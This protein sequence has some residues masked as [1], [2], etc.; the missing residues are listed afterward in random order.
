MIE[1]VIEKEMRGVVIM[2]TE[3]MRRIVLAAL[4][5]LVMCGAAS[6]DELHVPSQYVTIQAAID[7]AVN[8]D[9]VI[10]ADD[11]YT[12]TGN[13]NLDFNS[14]AITVRSE[15]GPQACVI[16][17]ENTGRGAYFSD[18]EGASSILKGFAI[19]N[20]NESRGGGI[21]ITNSSPTIINCIIKDNYASSSGGI[22]GAGFYITGSSANPRIINC[23]IDNNIT[24][25]DGGGVEGTYGASLSL[26]NCTIVRNQSDNAPGVGCH[27]DCDVVLTNTVVWYNQGNTS[28]YIANG[29]GSD[30]T[31]TNC[32]IEGGLALIWNPGGGSVIDNGGNIELVPEFI[33]PNNGDFNL[34]A[35]SPCI[36]AGDNSSV[37]VEATTDIAG[38]PRIIGGVVDIGA[39]EF[40]GLPQGDTYHVDGVN[41]NDGNDG[42]SRETAFATIQ[43]GIDT[44]QDGNSVVVWP[45]VYPEPIDFLGKA[46]TVQSADE[47]AVLEAPMDYAVSFYMGE[48]ADSVLKN[49]IITNSYLGIFIAGSSPTISNITVVGN[50]S[51]IEAYVGS[52][53]D[54]H[55]CIFWDN[56]DDDLF[57]CEARYSFVEEDIEDGLVSYWKLDGDAIDSAGNNN[58]T[59]YG[60]TPTTGQ[61]NDALDFDGTN[62]YVEIA[63]E[64]FDFGSDTDFSVCA[65]IKTTYTSDRRKIVDKKMAGH[66]PYTGFVFY[67]D[68]GVAIFNLKD[69]ADSVYAVTTSIV[70]DGNWHFIAGVADRDGDIQIYH[71]GFLEDSESLALVDN[72]NNNVPLAIG[73]SMDYNGQY[74]DGSIDDVRIYDRALSAEEIEVIYKA[75]LAG[76]ELGPLFADA[77]SGDYHLLSERGRYWPT[78]DVW[79]LDNVSSPCIDSGEPNVWPS[80]EPMPNGGR[81]NMGAYGNTV[82]ASMSEWSLAGDINRDG[83]VNFLDFAILAQGWLEGLPWAE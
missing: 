12:G 33:D 67:T 64:P 65:W 36:E 59:I 25:G 34:L 42:L 24:P 41:G 72:I 46:I 26:I 53:P 77:S 76:R 43:K 62:D 22:G 13:K 28:E 74:F 19:I 83:A 1:R 16:D 47:P 58:G 82:Y 7:A 69:N 79:V 8:G 48:G 37:P 60:A 51:G 18:G 31:L 30:T 2:E 78:Y 54:I 3:K 23:I 71:N 32:N 17:C 49:F 21:Y 5:V 10:V 40:Q 57:G 11:T 27:V 75:G 29:D 6:A 45:G 80:E 50:N 35:A 55:S 52:E 4:V 44:A 81:I 70:N 14:K 9:E 68:S 38:N 63:D 66:A 39:Y 56:T 61:I 15:N 20:G 73:R